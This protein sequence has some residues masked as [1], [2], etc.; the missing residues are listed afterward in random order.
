MSTFDDD[1]YLKAT[2]GCKTKGNDIQ[3]G[4]DCTHPRVGPWVYKVDKVLAVNKQRVHGQLQPI[5][6]AFAN[7]R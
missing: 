3:Q 2:Q 7:L 4:I 5:A 6:G 1:L